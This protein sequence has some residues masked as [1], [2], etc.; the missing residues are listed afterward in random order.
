MSVSYTAGYEAASPY[1][2]N[3]P[4]ILWDSARFQEVTAPSGL[5]T[6]RVLWSE[7]FSNAAWIKTNIAFTPDAVAAPDGSLTADQLVENTATAVHLTSQVPGVT[8]PDNATVTLSVYVKANGRD[9][10]WL[11]T[12]TKAITFPNAFFN[13]AT[14]VVAATFNGASATITPVGGGWYRC[15]LTANVLT[16]A[17][18]PQFTCGPSVAANSAGRT[19]LG[20]GSSGV[21]L[22]G[23]QFEVGAVATGYIPTTSVQASSSLTGRNLNRLGVPDT[24]TFG[25]VEGT[26]V[27]S[28]LL[29]FD[30]ARLV[31][32]VGIAGHNLGGFQV[33]IW[34]YTDAGLTTSVLLT[35]VVPEDDS[36][37]LALFA[38][39]SLHGIRIDV[40]GLVFPGPTKISV[41]YAG[42]AL[43]VPVRG[44]NDLGPIDLGMEVGIN[45]YRTETGQIAGRFVDYAGLS[46]NLTFT[47]LP[48]PWVRSTLLPFLKKAVTTPFFVATRPDGYPED[49]AYAW[50]TE[51]VIPQRMRLKNYM[52]VSMKVHAHAPVSLF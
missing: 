32:A 24:S 35:S 42:S 14:G 3:H 12:R 18:A 44:Y 33:R 39:Q 36:T 52:S 31:D 46:G 29:S 41:V 43:V 2:M 49:C 20:N 13:L 9:F 1:P 8:P 17:G 26:G 48:E 25:T 15:T 34:G 27:R 50:T 10:F 16:G 4:R 5:F 21:Y 22:W 30:A 19:Y 51:N 23:A 45:T 47:H 6:N 28:F 7:A 37:I 38:V 11:E 40:D